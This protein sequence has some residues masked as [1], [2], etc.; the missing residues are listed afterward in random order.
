MF[1]EMGHNTFCLG[2]VFKSNHKNMMKK[3]ECKAVY[4]ASILEAIPIVVIVYT[5]HIVVHV[6]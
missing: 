5:S 3:N 4:A 1:Y 2:N 6:Q